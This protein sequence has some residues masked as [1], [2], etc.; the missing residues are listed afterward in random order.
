MTTHRFE[1]TPVNELNRD[2]IL[3]Q[4][5][6][7]IPL[8]NKENDIPIPPPLPISL[9]LINEKNKSSPRL[10]NNLLQRIKTSSSTADFMQK[11]DT[12]SSLQTN[13]SYSTA[14]LTVNKEID[15]PDSVH[16]TIHS[17]TLDANS[18][19]LTNKFL[20]E[21]RLKRRELHAK[22][23]NLSIDERIAINRFQYERDIKRA[24]DIFD[25]HFEFNDDD[26]NN[27]MQN[28]IFNEDTQEKIRNNIFY[29]LDRQRMK[30]YH[31]QHRQLIVGR[32]LLIFITSLLA[33]MS[34]TLIYVVIDLYNR[35]NYFDT[36]LVDNEF[37]PMIYD[38]QNGV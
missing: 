23:R 3:S 10:F 38:D 35:A 11:N 14:N 9:T 32:A 5:P 31:K 15:E 7:M 21:L 24:Q 26:N 28:N 36:Q 4:L 17:N 16:S 13:H 30:Q 8:I 20:H 6:E 2:K 25:V 18:L 33:F 37:L 34:I 1:I 22:A 29:E 19:H 27:N 12:S